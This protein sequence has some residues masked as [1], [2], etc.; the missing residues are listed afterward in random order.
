MAVTVQ[1]L[2]NI[3]L[4]SSAAI[5]D[6]CN[7]LR[8]LCRQLGDSIEVTAAMLQA[9]LGAT[10][11]NQNELSKSDARMVAAHLK[12]AR[13]AVEAAGRQAIKTNAS[14]RRRYMDGVATAKRRPPIKKED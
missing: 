14:F 10:P 9:D 11:N 4:D 13:I 1:A 2:N 8:E 7:K 5:A 12:I 3:D 6:Y